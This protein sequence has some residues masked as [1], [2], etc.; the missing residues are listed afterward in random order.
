MCDRPAPVRGLATSQNFLP[1]PKQ[2]EQLTLGARR[3]AHFHP[4]ALPKQKTA[5]RHT[6]LSLSVFFFF[7]D[8]ERS[9]ARS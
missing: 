4:R 6:A 7:R 9:A 3:G 2:P 5:V 8:V 1:R